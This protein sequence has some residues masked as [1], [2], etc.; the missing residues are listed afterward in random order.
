MRTHCLLLA[1]LLSVSVGLSQ[2]WGQSPAEPLFG[3]T[4]TPAEERAR[5]ISA[6]APSVVD[7]A[8]QPPAPEPLSPTTS[9]TAAPMSQAGGA[10][11]SAPGASIPAQ[12][13]T[14]TAA[15]ET[16]LENY[17]DPGV[18]YVSYPD[19]API[20]YIPTDYQEAPGVSLYQ[21]LSSP[22]MLAQ[23]QGNL[24]LRGPVPGSFIVPGSTTAIRISGFVRIGQTFDF[25]A[26][27]TPDLFVTRAI[28]VPQ[29][30]SQNTNFSARPT[31][32]SLDTWTPT[33][34]N[35]WMFHTFIQG[36]F[37]SGNPPAVGSSSNPRLRFAFVDFGYFRVG[38]D[39]TVFMDPSV[40]PRTADFQGPNGMVN[41]RQGL[42][43]V[44]LPIGDRMRFAAAM[45]Q[46]FSDITTLNEGV[47]VQ[48]VPDFTSHL[49]YQ[50]DRYHFQAS[51]I[52]RAIGY[53]P[54]GEQVTRRGGWGVNLTS[55][56]HPWA[57][58]M[59][60][61]PIQDNDPDGLTRSRVLLQCALGQGIGR[62][63]QDPSG[64]GLDGAVT[65]NGGFETLPATS[66]T[67][68]YEHWYNRHWLSNFTFSSV[69]M[70]STDAL[71]ATTFSSSKYLAASLWWVPVRNVSIGA[72]YLWG[73]RQ[74]LN[75]QQGRASRI[76]TVAQYNF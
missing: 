34:F 43:R 67:A 37:L 33:S 31:R 60:T 36:D 16:A 15:L 6:P 48:D 23:N 39:T 27:S 61:N 26:I 46:P 64:I 25:D 17:D 71:P 57:M 18:G 76:Q 20:G 7:V 41:S 19:Y 56:F 45:E 8:F 68:S 38:Q 75:G 66:W 62:Y 44:T 51:T 65:A 28:A 52:L 50:A 11:Q 32:L 12:Y 40:F 35:D 24:V 59:H 14:N 47:N 53:R 22:S 70:G 13:R 55:G 74:N 42:F 69:D 49:R 3:T 2:A 1:A 9:S 21:P 30:A 54:D 10:Y 5:L 63:I 73:E 72:E 4:S 58:L 29:F